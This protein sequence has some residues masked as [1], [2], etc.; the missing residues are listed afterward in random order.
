MFLHVSPGWR[1]GLRQRGEHSST[2]R[3]NS[4]ELKLQNNEGGTASAAQQPPLLASGR[5][6]TRRGQK[7]K[8]WEEERRWGGWCWVRSSITALCGVSRQDLSYLKLFFK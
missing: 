4:H 6:D 2:K 5:H 8:G 1:D 3:S 7:N